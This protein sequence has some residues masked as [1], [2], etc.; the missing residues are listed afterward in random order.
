MS[1][2]LRPCVRSSLLRPFFVVSENRGHPG[3]NI[4]SP[5]VWAIGRESARVFSRQA[6]ISVARNDFMRHF[7][8]LRDNSESGPTPQRRVDLVAIR[9][10]DADKARFAL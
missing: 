5:R 10:H 8:N 2:A 1:D 4:H 6:D 3:A 7:M 9:T